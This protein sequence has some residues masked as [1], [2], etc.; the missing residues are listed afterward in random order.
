MMDCLPLAL[1][2]D[3]WSDLSMPIVLVTICHSKEFLK[4]GLL[5]SELSIITHYGVADML[6]N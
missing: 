6:D 4:I 1:I 3:Y 5:K 2:V